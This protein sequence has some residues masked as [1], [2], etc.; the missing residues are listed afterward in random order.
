VIFQKKNRSNS[1]G[2]ISGPLNKSQKDIEEIQIPNNNPNPTADSATGPFTFLSY[3]ET[4][5]LLDF[6]EIRND[7]DDALNSLDKGIQNKLRKLVLD[8]DPTPE[9]IPPKKKE[10]TL[11]EKPREPSLSKLDKFLEFIKDSSD[12]TTSTPV[13]TS[14]NTSAAT[15]GLNMT[16]SNIMSDNSIGKFAADFE[17]KV[18]GKNRFK[19]MQYEEKLKDKKLLALHVV[20]TEGS[21]LKKGYSEV[22]CSVRLGQDKQITDTI[23]NTNLIWNSHF[24]FI[25]NPKEGL[26]KISLECYGRD[27]SKED[28]IGRCTVPFGSIMSDFIEKKEKTILENDYLLRDTISGS[29][30]MKLYFSSSL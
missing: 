11:K 30:R 18:F 20:V 5:S 7:V 29:L 14:S 16:K 1:T 19:S 26:V 10:E 6:I 25:V 21:D 17:N 27:G 22:Y 12:I 24:V 8:R 2:E 3:T 23:Q 28:C 15:T 13:G 4:T 9:K